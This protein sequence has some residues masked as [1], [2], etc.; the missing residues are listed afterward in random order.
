MSAAWKRLQGKKI[1]INVSKLIVPWVSILDGRGCFLDPIAQQALLELQGES[2]AF[3]EFFG[4][5]TTA[6][7]AKTFERGLGVLPVS[8]Q[9]W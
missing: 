9:M 3:L 2:L 7:F 4:P 1:E 8:F 6:R 5:T